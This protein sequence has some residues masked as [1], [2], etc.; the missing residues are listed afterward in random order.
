MSEQLG[1]TDNELTNPITPFT[2]VDG[3]KTEMNCPVKNLILIPKDPTLFK[4]AKK[5]KSNDS[6][7]ELEMSE[8]KENKNCLLLVANTLLNGVDPDTKVPFRQSKAI[9]FS[10][11][12]KFA[13]E[14]ATYIND[15]PNIIE[16]IDPTKKY[17]MQYAS[18]C[19]DESV[20]S[21]EE[22]NRELQ[23]II[24]NFKGKISAYFNEN[25]SRTLEQAFQDTIE[26]I[27]KHNIGI[28]IY[29]ISNIDYAKKS[30]KEIYT[31]AFSNFKLA[32]AEHSKVAGKE[33]HRQAFQQGRYRYL[34]GVES[35]TEGFD[36]PECDL[37]FEIARTGPTL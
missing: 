1:F 3:I 4:A 24:Q 6:T 35:L 5:Q 26:P 25:P 22:M 29:N 7:I 28:K 37:L 27:N 21:D 12:I 19:L 31:K 20:D 17:R 34:I 14:L 9:A 11:T 33:D 32:Q 23:S 18:N 36:N 8:P 10:P 2:L 13:E 15:V 30:V 16:V